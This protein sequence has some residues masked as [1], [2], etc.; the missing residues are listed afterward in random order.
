MTTNTKSLVT[1]GIGLATI[2]VSLYSYCRDMKTAKKVEKA[3][4][5]IEKASS[6]DISDAMIKEAVNRTVEKAVKNEVD[7]LAKEIV[8]EHSADLRK[9]VANVISA[10]KEAVE[11]DVTEELKKQVSSMSA[12]ELRKEVKLEAKEK[13]LRKLEKDMDEISYQYKRHLE[14]YGATAT[15]G[16][17]IFSLNIG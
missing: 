9:Q 3:V 17:G 7:E 13:M 8:K 12:K 1:V 10:A 11:K 5:D 6:V 14:K 16:N 4:E 2:A 15:S